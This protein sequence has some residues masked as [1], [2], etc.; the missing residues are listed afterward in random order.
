MIVVLAE[1]ASV[2]DAVT[3]ALVVLEEV[4]LLTELLESLVEIVLVVVLVV[5]ELFW[6]LENRF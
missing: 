4:V 2:V 5:V 1:M 3:L 6:V